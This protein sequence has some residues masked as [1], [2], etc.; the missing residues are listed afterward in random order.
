VW[1][2]LDPPFTGPAWF[3]DVV[4]VIVTIAKIGSLLEHQVWCPT[5]MPLEFVP[6]GS[7]RDL[8]CQVCDRPGAH[9]A[10]PIASDH[11]T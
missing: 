2:V 5:H 1:R 9:H 3:D 4:D 10:L 11:G 7:A 6:A 8:H